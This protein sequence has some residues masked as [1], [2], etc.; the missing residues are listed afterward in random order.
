MLT[1]T[2][3][4]VSVISVL[5]GSPELTRPPEGMAFPT[6]GLWMA[7]RK[8]ESSWIEKCS[9]ISPSTIPKDLDLAVNDPQ[10]FA[11][12]AELARRGA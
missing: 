1:V 2:D 8:P 9:P 3:A 4:S 12:I 6:A 7:S 5:S 10:G 11:Q